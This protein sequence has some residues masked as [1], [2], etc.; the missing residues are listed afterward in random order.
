MEH[1]GAKDDAKLGKDRSADQNDRRDHVASMCADGDRDCRSDC[2]KRRKC[3]AAK[4]SARPVHTGC[5]TEHAIEVEAE[6][7]ALATLSGRFDRRPL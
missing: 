3:D 1:L 5:E 6:R 7:A 2:N 4:D